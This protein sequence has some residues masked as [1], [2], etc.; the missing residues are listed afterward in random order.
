MASARRRF[1]ECVALC[2]EVGSR[3][4]IAAAISNLGEVVNKQGEHRLARNL[5]EEALSIFREIED[6]VG[7]G[8]CNVGVLGHEAGE[9]GHGSSSRR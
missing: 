5:F 6:A 8:C 7:T 2:R 9:N 4:A 3:K 1:E